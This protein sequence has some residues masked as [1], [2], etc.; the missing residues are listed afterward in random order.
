MNNL[1]SKIVGAT[2]RR[3]FPKAK[4]IQADGDI[5]E[6]VCQIEL[7]TP[8]DE[9]AIELLEENLC[10][11][12]PIKHSEMMREN[13]ASLFNHHNQPYLAQQALEKQQNIIPIVQIGDQYDL[14]C[15][16]AEPKF[17]KISSYETK[18][19]VT[20]LK[21]AGFSNKQHLKKYFKEL[22]HKRSCDHRLLGKQLKLFD[23][24]LWYPRGA[25]LYRT[26]QE[27][28]NKTQEKRQ[29]LPIIAPDPT[30]IPTMG[31]FT[32]WQNLHNPNAQSE[33]WGLLD[34]KNSTS[35]D[36]IIFCTE[37]EANDLQTSS[38]QF[39]TKTITILG[40]KYQ[41]V[42]TDARKGGSAEVEALD[43]GNGA[44]LEV[45]DAMGRSWGVGALRADLLEGRTMI[46]ETFFGSIERF[47]ALLIE[48][49][50]GNLPLW[51]VPEQVVVIPVS[52][53][54]HAYAEQT[55]KELCAQGWR[56]TVNLDD[57]NV[58]ARV[59]EAELL[60][61]P[62]LIVVG[63][64]EQKNNSIALRVCQSSEVKRGVRLEELLQILNE[65]AKPPEYNFY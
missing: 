9:K 46:R 14:G 59:Q 30:Q 31:R 4:L 17:I 29:F 21:G 19:G 64:D 8:L 54:Y 53:K 13:A 57:T 11:I 55:K 32:Q 20:T 34:P 44:H 16:P 51:L 35:D 58:A 33:L 2:L 26:L 42:Y 50:A 39:I 27:W 40:F 43:D 12:P 22:P 63:E 23:G 18:E 38:L 47:I 7:P 37:E 3:M 24:P 6:F 1:A 45:Q 48:T 62:F 28:W 36:S 5:A 60:K 56:A 10:Q 61:I 49:T 52:E 15:D 65:E 25:I 41:W